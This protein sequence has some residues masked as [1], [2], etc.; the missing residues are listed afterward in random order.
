MPLSLNVG[1]DVSN[2]ASMKLLIGAGENGEF[3]MFEDDGCSKNFENGDFVT[4]KF[5]TEYIPEKGV[6]RVVIHG[7]EGNLALIPEKRI[8]E[9]QVIGLE[10]KVEN[11]VTPEIPVQQDYIWEIEGK[12]KVENDIEQAA[13]SILEN[14]WMD[15]LEKERTFDAVRSCKSMDELKQWISGANISLMVKDALLELM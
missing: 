14:G 12:L 4:T 7:A 15:I 1:N 10:G 5:T 11:H 13:F 6:T 2:P 8:Y 9:I 3:I